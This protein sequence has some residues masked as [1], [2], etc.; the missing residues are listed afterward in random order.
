MKTLLKLDWLEI[1]WPRP[2]SEDAVR[3]LLIHLA[4]V[5]RHGHLAFEIRAAHGK[6]RY[7]L[8][9]PP[10]DSDK[11]T[12]VFT[13]VLPQV[14]FR[15]KTEYTHRQKVTVAGSIK[16]SRPSLSL[17]THRT[18]AV[19][20]AVLASLAQTKHKGDETLLQIILGKSITPSLLPDKI[21]DP[22]ASWLDLIRGSVRQ[23]TG[24]TKRLMREKA[25][26]HGFYSTIRIGA[27]SKDNP[28]P[29][30]YIHAV[31]SALKTIETAGAKLKLTTCNPEVLNLV[32]RPW[33]FQ[34]HLSIKEL[35]AFL[36]WPLGEAEFIG[37]AGMHPRVM[38]PPKGFC[39]D[40]RSFGTA[41]LS[42]V[43]LSIS[44]SD[45]LFQNVF[46]GPTGAG[47]SN[48]MLSLIMAD[49]H[50]NRSI[51]VIDPKNDFV[52]NILERTPKKREKDIV[53]INPS[54]SCPVGLNMLNSNPQNPTLTADAILATF[55][56]LF[57][58]SWG[59]RTQDILSAALLTL[60]KIKGA[61]LIWLPA[62][63][64]D[65]NFRRKILKNISD[66]VGLDA[67]WAS[68]E[69]MSSAERTQA[70][71]PV[72]NKLRQFLLRPELRAVL[73]QSNPKFNLSDLFHKRRIVLVEL[74][75]GVI[76]NEVA[77]LMGSLL[78]SQLWG[79]AL[80]R[81]AISPEKRHIVHVYIDEV[82][83][84]LRLPGDLSDSLSQ[85]RALGLSLC[86][87]HQFR[88]QLPPNL[89][90]AIDANCQ[91]KVVFGLNASD[92]RDMAAMAPGLD[93]T[94]FMLLPRYAVYAQLQNNGKNAGWISGRTSPPTPAIR[95]ACD[96]KAESM[97]TYGRDAGEVEREYLKAI[98]H[99]DDRE[100]NIPDTPIGRRKKDDL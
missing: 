99:A 73:G 27:V 48:A 26:H 25:E 16:P 88:N 60:T 47:K 46:L 66:P 29:H 35:P 98:G 5:S 14:R 65:D 2:F 69:A 42:N 43:P 37:V 86:V 70:I 58:D 83:D 18:E 84:Y 56:S 57:A 55:Q 71:G 80:G 4:T 30:G 87:A 13:S 68:F 79:L 17:S 52:R 94:D 82:Q 81:A 74:N 45:S 6:I 22:T 95:S 36:S 28:H 1:I 49:I 19:I 78:V 41:T 24:E 96:L 91:N 21:P 12:E 97:M 3:E 67:F 89:R 59:V 50:A 54:D 7:L 53:V 8:G 72:M 10:Q 11:I 32:T 62:L 61:T 23:A 64:T 15:T 76:G 51:C 75:K 63:L 39:G 90:A 85:A 100:T 33:H 34:T 9:V 44:A 77:K 38:L 40:S 20:R 92:A 31:H 93:P